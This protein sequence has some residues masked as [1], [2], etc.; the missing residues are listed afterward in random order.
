MKL[1]S[2]AYASSAAVSSPPCCSP[3]ALTAYA[4][5]RI[6][7]CNTERTIE[8][9]PSFDGKDA[10]ALTSSADV[11]VPSMIPALIS[12]ASFSLAKSAII[13]AG[14]TTSSVE[15]AIAFGPVKNSSIPSI[16]AAAAERRTKVFLYTLNSTPASRSCLRSSVTCATVKPR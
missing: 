11:T 10:I 6:G 14:A 4:K 7:A 5:L 9:S 13:L 1:V 15:N 3:T 2:R 8:I 12:N 16:P